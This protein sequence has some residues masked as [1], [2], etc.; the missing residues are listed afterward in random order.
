MV[1]APD[2]AP[3]VK[4]SIMRGYDAEV[5]LCEST[6]TARIETCARLA[7]ERGLSILPSYDHPDVMAGQVCS[8]RFSASRPLCIALRCLLLFLQKSVDVLEYSEICDCFHLPEV[9]SSSPG[10]AA[11]AAAA[12]TIDMMHIA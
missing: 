1:V 3:A 10:R 11:A 2:N 12:V 9:P 8:L 7:K 4:L 5:V 6:P